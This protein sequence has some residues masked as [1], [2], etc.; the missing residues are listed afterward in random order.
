MFGQL[1]S[2]KFMQKIYF[3]TSNEYKFQ[4]AVEAFKN[5]DFKLVQKVLDTPEIQSENLGEIASYSIK[6]AA[7][8]LKHPV[9]L[10]DAGC[11]IESLKGFPGPFIKYINQYLTAPDFLKLLAGKK[12][13]KVV[14]KDCLAY[15]E[16]GKDPVLFFS[17]GEG[18]IATKRGKRGS[19]AINEIFIPKGFDKPE[20]EIPRDQM[21]KFWNKNVKNFKALEK[22]LK[23]KN[24][25]DNDR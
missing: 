25:P 12:N 14:F 4:I 16:P 15:C 19:T 17:R 20:S 9:F 8:K 5:S 6:W 13:R 22:Y 24:C 21:I 11:F 2:F 10:S 1:L 3:I 7:A 23:N 18:T